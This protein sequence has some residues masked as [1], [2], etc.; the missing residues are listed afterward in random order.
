MNGGRGETRRILGDSDGITALAV[1]H[2]RFIA[3][4]PDGR[5]H[6]HSRSDNV[7]I[8]VSGTGNFTVDGVTHEVRRGTILHIPAGTRHSVRNDAAEPLEILE[9]HAPGGP[10]FDFV[11][12]A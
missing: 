6:H 2:H 7:F 11:V 3:H 1:Q 5:T 9:V 8:V 12:D 10:D 4:G